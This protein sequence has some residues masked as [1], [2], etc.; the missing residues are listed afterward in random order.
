LA[1]LLFVTTVDGAYDPVAIAAQLRR[2]LNDDA[3]RRG[4][5]GA[6]LNSWIVA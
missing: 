4:L 1:V 2:L 5:K 3:V 6:V